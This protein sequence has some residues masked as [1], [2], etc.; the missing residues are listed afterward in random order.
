MNTTVIARLVTILSF[1]VV[2]VGIVMMIVNRNLASG[3]PFLVISGSLAGV[4]AALQFHG[5]KEQV[6]S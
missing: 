4:I 6:H 5:R 1:L 2:C 3:L